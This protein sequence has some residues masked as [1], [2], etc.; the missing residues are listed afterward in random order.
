[1]LI[2]ACNEQYKDL[3][4]MNI[5][6]LINRITVKFTSGW[7]WTTNLKIYTD[8]FLPMLKICV[9]SPVTQQNHILLQSFH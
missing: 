6:D 4:L 9:L 2:A 8:K 7:G 1:M 3:L 5:F